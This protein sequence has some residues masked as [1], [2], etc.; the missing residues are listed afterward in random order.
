MHFRKM[1]LPT[2]ISRVSPFL[3]LGVLGGIFH[4]SPIFIEI[5]LANSEDPDQTLLFCSVSDP[6]LHCLSMSHKNLNMAE[7]WRQIVHRIFHLY[8]YFVDVYSE[9][10]LDCTFAQAWP[11]YLLLAFWISTKILCPD[12]FII[13]AFITRKPDTVSWEHQRCRPSAQSDQHLYYSLSD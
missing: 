5:L 12:S 13:Q 8:P 11:C 2:L 6:G 10:W 9:D 4:F 7:Y 1:N 3:I